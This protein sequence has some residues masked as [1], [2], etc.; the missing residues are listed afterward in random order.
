MDY[1]KI[2]S[3]SH[4]LEKYKNLIVIDTIMLTSGFERVNNVTFNSFISVESCYFLK[5]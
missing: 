2:Q 1:I 3:S 5:S 4:L